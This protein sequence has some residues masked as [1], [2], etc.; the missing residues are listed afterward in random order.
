MTKKEDKKLRPNATANWKIAMACARLQ[1]PRTWSTSASYHI[2]TNLNTTCT[3]KPAS[4]QPQYCNQPL[5]PN[6]RICLFSF[7]CW[8]D[9]RIMAQWQASVMELHKASS[10][11]DSIPCLQPSQEHGGCRMKVEENCKRERVKWKRRREE[12]SGCVTVS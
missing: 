3:Y 11:E 1:G 9:G 6:T 5:D 2:Y 4:F 10:R 8:F 12:W 7:V